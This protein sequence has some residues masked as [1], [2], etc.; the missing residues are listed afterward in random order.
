MKKAVMY[1]AGNIGRGFIGKTFSE[2]GYEVCFVDIAEDIV[3]KLNEDRCY[4][5]RIVSN[6]VKTVEAVYNVRAVN[7]R[8][9]ESVANEIAGAD[10]M[11]AAV[12]VNALQHIKKPLCAGLKKRFDKG[13]QPLNI[14]ICENLI[15]ADV[16]IRRLIDEEMGPEYKAVLDQ[17]LGLVE[18]SIGRMVPIMTDEMRE[19]NILSVWAEPYDKLPVDKAAFIG[20]VPHL[21]GIVPFSPFGFYI[22][23][24]LF[25]HNM[26]HAMCAYFGW[27]KGYTYIYECVYDDEIRNSVYAAMKETAKALHNEYGITTDEINEHIEDLLSRFGNV[28]LGDTVSRVGRDP[29]RK[30]GCNDRLIGAALYCM[31]QGCDASNVIEGIVAALDYNNMED[32]VAADMQHTIKQ[33]GIKAFL[34]SHCGLSGDS[35]LLLKVISRY[36]QQGKPK[37][38]MFECKQLH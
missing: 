11:A 12:G 1:G 6:D 16:Y 8:D 29:L 10:I 22:K 38:R 9:I 21:K 19:G 3:G 30:L 5:V 15:D 18:A 13:G 4:P 17:K 26:S 28:F 36:Q 23:R 14:I 2:S 27:Q 37:R 35:A 20:E 34:M 24:K 25:I 32:A 33:Q 31:S 7:G